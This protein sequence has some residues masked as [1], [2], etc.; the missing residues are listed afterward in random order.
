MSAEH[1]PTN[2]AT[3]WGEAG[4]ME[5]ITLVFANKDAASDLQQQVSNNQSDTVASTTKAPERGDVA[6]GLESDFNLAAALSNL[7]KQSGTN[8]LNPLWPSLIVGMAVFLF[9]IIILGYRK[10]K[11][12]G[13]DP[14]FFGGS[15]GGPGDLDDKPDNVVVHINSDGST[16]E[17]DDAEIEVH[18]Q[19]Y[20]N[21]PTRDE[22]ADEYD[23]LEER[24]RKERDLDKQ[25]AAGCLGGSS[26]LDTSSSPTHVSDE[27]D[28]IDVD[29]YRYGSSSRSKRKGGGGCFGRGKKKDPLQD[30]DSMAY[31]SNESRGID[32]PRRVDLTTLGDHSSW[33]NPVRLNQDHY[34]D[35]TYSDGDLTTAEKNKFNLYM[36]SGMSI[37]EASSQVLRERTLSRNA[38]DA[39]MAERTTATQNGYEHEYYDGD[40]YDH[41]PVVTPPPPSATTGRRTGS[42][43]WRVGQ[44]QRLNEKQKEIIRNLHAGPDCDKSNPLAC[45]DG[46][47]NQNSFET[48]NS[49]VME[50]GNTRI[51]TPKS[52]NYMSLG[53]TC[54]ST[55]S[56]LVRGILDENGISTSA[57]SNS[58]IVEK[59]RSANPNMAQAMIITE[60]SSYGSSFDDNDFEVALD[61][62]N[63]EMAMA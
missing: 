33:R 48:L 56:S 21:N 60:A 23:E 11:A 49:E 42:S 50:D 34:H 63:N 38:A 51:H 29:D 28:N 36:Q 14:F 12:S 46:G 10:Q 3:P 24:R 32:L 39:A 59:V 27:E 61:E 1:F 2:I 44:K 26:A 18:D 37:E 40:Y 41:P 22:L 57:S 53:A 58:S 52:K 4:V 20:S 45:F 55:D 35:D 47:I 25:Y 6:F 54:S 13:K 7:L 62:T 43:R 9:T 16:L 19:L 31:D 8:R 17:G 30:Q 15:R 5:E